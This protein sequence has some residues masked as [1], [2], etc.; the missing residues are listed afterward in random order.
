MSTKLAEHG[1]VAD[2]LKKA[3]VEAASARLGIAR[4]VLEQYFRELKLKISKTPDPSLGDYG[5]ALHFLFYKHGV[6]RDK[7]GDIASEIANYME[8]KGYFSKCHIAGAEFVNGYLNFRIDYAGLLR[9]ILV[10]LAEGSFF[11]RL[12]ELGRGVRVVVEHTSANPI[13]PLHIGSGRNAVLG[14]T[15]ARLLRYLGFSVS[16]HFYVNDMGKQV[17]ILVY[18]YSLLEKHGVT[19]PSSVKIDHWY[20]AVYA[21]TNIL[22]EKLKLAEELKKTSQEFAETV[23]R[24]TSD[25]GKLFN[26]YK[27]YIFLDLSVLLERIKNELLYKH[28]VNQLVVQLVERIKKALEEVGE[29]YGDAKSILSSYEK[30]LADIL[31]AMKSLADS[32]R[33]YSIAEGAIAGRYPE[34]YRVLKEEIRDPV[35]A[36]KGISELM[37]KY[38]EGDKE[39]SS[40]FNRVVSSVMSGIVDTLDKLGIVFDRFDWESRDPGRKY[41]AEVL[42]RI[43]SSPYGRVEGGALIVDLDKAAMEHEYIRK[44]FEPDHPGKLV[45]RRSDGT[46][47]YTARDVVYS[48]YKFKDVGADKVYNVIATEQTREQKQ[49]K[50]ILYLLGYKKCAENLVH[51]YYEMVN[52]KNMRMSSRRGQ[53]YALDELIEDYTDTVAHK[54]IENQLK[55]GKDRASLSKEELMKAFYDLGV[56]CTRALLLSIDP[57]KTLTFDPRKIEEYDIGSWI[58][59]TFV[60]LQ[61]ILRRAYGVEPLENTEFYIE[62]LNKLRERI[63]GVEIALSSE[64]KNV[65]EAISGFQDA[66]LRAY[67]D[68]EP[69]KV[70][71]YTQ[72]L[73]T[74]LNKLYETHPVLG[75]KDEVKRST[76]LALVTSSLLLL[77]DLLWIMGFPLIKKL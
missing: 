13:H 24:M 56:A 27:H 30:E 3:F 7:W 11:K 71:E 76:R 15:F 4:A 58:V 25:I 47:L 5:I 37:A 33:E 74:H 18:G 42:S 40:L 50:A 20:G 59:Y 14:N 57:S 17:A 2:C 36:E 41:L 65:I 77:K 6:E 19:P 44:L 39:V 8:E 70:L 51:F 66:L 60:R 22:I 54:Y 1:V 62:K 64:E 38:E 31:D 53:Y 32:M 49:V 28:D 43:E 35:E 26:K 21:L 16:E 12:H 9:K 67:R 72:Q 34:V 48:I 73:C 61:S 63:E 29:E 45:L 55:L 69:N 23:A 46:T 52:L 68:L 10:E 75:E